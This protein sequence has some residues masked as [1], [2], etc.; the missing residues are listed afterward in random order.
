MANP[1]HVSVL[2]MGSDIW[3]RWQ[4]RRSWS[5]P[6]FYAD[7]RGADLS[8]LDLSQADFRSANL[9]RANLSGTNL[10]NAL[11]G[12]GSRVNRT[13]KQPRELIS[14]EGG[15]T[16]IF[17]GGFTIQDSPLGGTD[18]TEANLRNANLNRAQFFAT[19][20]TGADLTDADLTDA[21]FSN[22]TVWPHGYDPIEHGA[23]P[24]SQDFTITFD[25]GLSPE[26]VSATLAAL[27]DFYRRVGGLGFR[28]DFELDDV[29]V[30]E[31]VHA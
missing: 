4:S 22:S 19:N 3:N 17:G 9:R 24:F 12:I 15:R 26:Q 30:M 31:P 25:E 23:V 27:A 16:L 28:V 8:G 2:R 18:L 20:L 1:E 14:Q 11:F 13:A 29:L 6:S 5:D 7:L 21:V 10:T